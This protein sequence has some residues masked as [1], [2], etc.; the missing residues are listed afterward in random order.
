MAQFFFLRPNLPN[1]KKNLNEESVHPQ[2]HNKN[3]YQH[4]RIEYFPTRLALNFFKIHN[5][6]CC[7]TLLTKYISKFAHTT[8]SL[9][10]SR[11]YTV[12]EDRY[13]HLKATCTS[14][15]TNIFSFQPSHRNE[16]FFL[17]YSKQIQLYFF[18]AE[19]TDAHT[20]FKIYCTGSR[21]SGNF[22]LAA[23]KIILFSL[24]STTE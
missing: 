23:T 14:N 3:N 5:F 19:K 15:P 10:V 2:L 13:L 1:G 17:Y 16:P 7:F 12:F 22:S 11:L 20:P 6:W 18:Y 9:S 21:T 8:F 24:S 4:A